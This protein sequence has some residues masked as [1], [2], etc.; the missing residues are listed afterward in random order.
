MGGPFKGYA[1]VFYFFF[2]LER[3]LSM[4][5]LLESLLA[6]FKKALIN[7]IYSGLDIMV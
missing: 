7:F 2:V 4:H 5:G 6:C 1:F 3:F